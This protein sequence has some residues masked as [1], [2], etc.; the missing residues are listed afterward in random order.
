MKPA[1]AFGSYHYTVIIYGFKN[2]F[3]KT[4]ATIKE[5]V[6][7]LVRVLLCILRSVTYT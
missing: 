4:V 5:V 3:K 2:G 6:S 7:D 1:K